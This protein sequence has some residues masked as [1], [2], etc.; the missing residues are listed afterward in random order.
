M[1]EFISGA[2][3][4]LVCTTIIESGLDIP[5]AN[6]MIIERCDRFG[7]AELYQL[8]GRI[9]RWKNQAY[10]Y[11]LLPEHDIITSDARKRIAAIRRYTQ[12]G[13]GFKL[14]LRDL[15]IRGSGNLL[16][17]E[18][19]GHI[20][21]IGFELYCQILRATVARL[22]GEQDLEFL[23]E[24]DI[25]IEFVSYGHKAP[26]GKI[27]ICIP[28]EYISSERLRLEAYRQ[29]CSASKH[30]EIDN[31]LNLLRDRYG[32]IPEETQDLARLLKIKISVA[33]AGFKSLK[34]M[35]SKIL[36]ENISGVFKQDGRIPRLPESKK[37]LETLFNIIQKFTTS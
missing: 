1:S 27:P 7:L 18:Q 34:V 11:M 30:S 26:P 8:R 28:P 2:I 14:A 22:K 31:V 15:E 3:D 32:R 12:L 20:N 13:A 29:I 25:A 17:Q 33:R 6:T 24:T 35:E 10:A 16:G 9:G 37:P 21:A 5:N 23:P 36:L 4:V 19:S